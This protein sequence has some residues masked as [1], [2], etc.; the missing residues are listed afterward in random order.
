M[1]TFRKKCGIR[2]PSIYVG[3][4]CTPTFPS[5]IVRHKS[6]CDH[7]SPNPLI[8]NVYGLPYGLPVI[9]HLLNHAKQVEG[10]IH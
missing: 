3:V 1:K 2:R 5:S 6:I 8:V 7:Y 4:Y 9:I 10:I